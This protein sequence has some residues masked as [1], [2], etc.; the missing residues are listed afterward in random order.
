MRLDLYLKKTRLVRQRSLA[1]ELCDAGAVS[2]N[3][4]RGKPGQ[5]VRLHDRIHLSLPQRSL[6]VRVCAIPRGNVARGAA[7]DFYE[8]LE[9]RHTDRVDSVFE[10]LDPNTAG[11]SD[12]DS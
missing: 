8:I 12:E 7:K 5:E 9:D 3:D 10:P 1:K 2:V 4:R 6:E 11:P